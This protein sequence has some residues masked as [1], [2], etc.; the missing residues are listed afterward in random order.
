MLTETTSKRAFLEVRHFRHLVRCILIT[1]LSLVLFGCNSAL[2]V[3]VST[4]V[5]KETATQALPTVTGTPLPSATPQAPLVILLAPNGSD[6]ELS[7]P[8]QPVLAELSVQAG[9]RFKL[10]PTLSKS[11]LT[12]QVKLVVA[13]APT[14]NLASLAVNAPSTQFLAIG[15]PDLQPGQNLSLV[16]S[17]AGRPDQ[18]G[19]MGGY[20]AALITKDWRVGVISTED[21]SG[22]A[23]RQGFFN[24]AIYYCGLCRPSYPPFYQ[25]P[26]YS[27]LAPGA[28]AADR[29]AAAD[30][31][32]DQ[33]VETVYI[34]P[35]AGDDSLLEYLAQAGVN[36]I[37]S[38]PPPVTVQNQWV[39]TLQTDSVSAVRKLWPDLLK[40][41][42]GANLESPIYIRDANEKLF[43]LGRQRMAQHTLE[44]LQAGFID[45]G[46]DPSMG[47]AR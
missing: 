44:E 18:L 3:G 17:P 30:Y 36:L 2:P 33:A 14:D 22:M 41:Q 46:I 42:G 27:E 45:T 7:G 23:A 13:L 11:D 47:E 43:S 34:A 24:G 28:S 37:G 32:I 35:G 5:S 12:S 16:G 1:L 8:L 15:V 26:L 31:L 38:S 6:T 4:A 10:L 39:A 25:Y 21:G 29:Q 20:I 9:L 40:G 19:F